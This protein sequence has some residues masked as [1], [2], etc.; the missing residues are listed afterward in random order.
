MTTTDTPLDD[1]IDP[2]V[3][4]TAMVLVVGALAV[5]FDTT[6]VSVALHQLA[7]DL[8]ASVTTIQ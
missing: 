8:H 7:V 6:I 4:K 5:V 3:L 2:Q 1:K